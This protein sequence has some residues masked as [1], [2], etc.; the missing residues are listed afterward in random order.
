M[1]LAQQV[2][3]IEALSITHSDWS[4]LCGPQGFHISCDRHEYV[5]LN[6]MRDS[7]LSVIGLITVR[8]VA[9][10]AVWWEPSFYIHQCYIINSRNRQV[11]QFPIKLFN[12]N[13]SW[14]AW[15]FTWHL[16]FLT[17]IQGPL[18]LTWFH[19]N[20]TM[21]YIHYKLWDEITYPFLNFNGATVEV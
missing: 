2:Y 11:I 1:V 18:L 15:F 16:A 7:P 9:M 14:D 17:S 4:K 13:I 8:G 19:F 5:R 21:D 3:C 6:A 20:H 10:T 12:Y